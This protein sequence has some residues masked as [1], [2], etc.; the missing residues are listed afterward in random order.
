MKLETGVPG[1]EEFDLA[2]IELMP[3]VL[4]FEIAGPFPFPVGGGRS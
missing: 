4:E 3:V 1:L 2:A